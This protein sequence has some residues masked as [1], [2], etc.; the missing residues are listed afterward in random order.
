[1]N[2]LLYLEQGSGNTYNDTRP[3]NILSRGAGYPLENSNISV[4]NPIYATHLGTSLEDPGHTGRVLGLFR[5]E[6]L[7]N[8][9]LD[10][11]LD[12]PAGWQTRSLAH[13]SPLE[14]MPLGL[15]KYFLE[16]RMMVRG[17]P[18]SHL[19]HFV[20]SGHVE[21]VKNE[22]IEIPQR[23][24][25]DPDIFYYRKRIIRDHYLY[26]FYQLPL[27]RVGLRWLFNG[28]PQ[29]SFENFPV[30]ERGMG[31]RFRGHSFSSAFDYL[32]EMTK[33]EGG[34]DISFYLMMPG[35]VIFRRYQSVVPFSGANARFHTRFI[36]SAGLRQVLLEPLHCFVHV[37][38]EFHNLIGQNTFQVYYP[39]GQDRNCFEAS[40]QWA[41]VQHLFQSGS[42]GEDISVVES[43]VRK[44]WFFIMTEAASK[45]KK[46]L[47]VYYRDYLK[48]GYPTKEMTRIAQ[49]VL[50][51][52]GY[53]V[54]VWYKKR[55]SPPQNASW[56]NIINLDTDEYSKD[57]N[58][59]DLAKRIVI[60]QCRDDGC[61]RDD[62]PPSFSASDEEAAYF[63][64]QVNNG[65]LGVML[66]CIGVFP[67]PL[68]LMPDRRP[69]VGRLRQNI[70]NAINE[71][72]TEYMME[73]YRRQKYWE[74]ITPDNLHSLVCAQF[75][76]YRN[77]ETNTLIFAPSAKKQK[78][79]DSN[80]TK[81]NII[82]KRCEQN[83]EKPVYYVFAYDLETV[84]NLTEI[85]E[86]MVYPP[87]QKVLP[88]SY[89]SRADLYEP[90]ESQIPFSCQ[91][92][93]VNVSDRGTYLSRK[94]QE[95]AR[96][97]G[98]ISFTSFTPDFDSENPEFFLSSARTEYSS[99]GN[100]DLGK[101][102]ED[103]LVNMASYV[104]ARGGEQA[105]CFAHNGAHFDAYIVLQFQRFE[106]RNVLKTSRGVMTVS[107]RVP[108][109]M[110]G[111]LMTYDYKVNDLDT[112]KV[113]LILRDTMLQVPGSLARLCKGFN[114]PKEYCKL[115]FPITKVNAQNFHH[116]RLIPL[117]KE[118]GENDVKALAVI[119]V[120]INDL[121]GSSQWKPAKL[122]SLKPPV[123][124][125]VTCMG[126]IR[127]STRIHFHHH[128]PLNQHPKAIDIPALRSWL[129]NA[130]IGGRV[131]AYAKT[132]VSPF[133]GKII[134]AYLDGNRPLLQ[135]LYAD[136]MEAKQCMRVLDFTSLYPFAMDSCPMP[137]GRLVFCTAEQCEHD[138]QR[139]ECHDCDAEMSLCSRHRLFENPSTSQDIRPFTIVIVKNLKMKEDARK[140]SLRNMCP[141]KTFLSST[142]KNVS[143]LYSL[144]HNEEFRK[145]SKEM[146]NVHET[147]SFSNVDLYWMRRQGFTFDIVA[148]FGFRVTNV[149]NLFIGPAFRDRIRAK[150][151]GNK[152]LSDFLKLNYNGSFGITTQQDI[153]DCYFP[154]RVDPSLKDHD[155][156]EPIVRKKIIE[157]LCQNR[158]VSDAGLSVTE[159][160]T[161]EAVYLP[162]GQALFQK[163]KKEHLAEYFADQSPM[164][165]GAAVLSWSR[166]IANL[167]MF[168]VHE[169]DQTYTDTDSICISDYRIHHTPAL[170]KMIIDRDDAPLGSLKN[171][172]AEN[173]GTEPRVFC[174]LIGTKKVKLHIT[175]NKE[176]DVRMF[177]TFK[178]LNVSTELDGKTF[179]AAY[180]EKITS[181]TL[182]HLNVDASTVPPVIVQSWRRNLEFGVSIS[183]HLQSMSPE[184]YFESCAGTSLFTLPHGHLEFF[185]PHGCGVRV[186]YPI[187]INE[188][189]LIM[190]QGERRRTDLESKIYHN[191]FSVDRFKEFI[192][193]Y[194]K[195]IAVE[196]TIEDENVKKA[197]DE[198]EQEIL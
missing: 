172:H 154:V 100:N 186:D 1:M 62:T 16:H 181:Q 35:C 36:R 132:Y 144:E 58:L 67:P 110:T 42:M 34:S 21:R 70:V 179:D 17:I 190:S 51:Q 160:L 78:Q 104:H 40:V 197:F 138:I 83:D 27:V 161:G 39:S 54:E 74:D 140:E 141:R 64:E 41:M 171:D 84:K 163:K 93:A 173:N 85:Q 156:K 9:F 18:A 155:P 137:T 150:Q 65:D 119:I 73:M 79:E 97:G 37:H 59:I 103:M 125:F 153:T 80:N 32:N 149:Y 94:Q 164:Q 7:T 134:S 89:Q 133:A 38:D 126:M 162:N 169:L 192:E 81:K 185:I 56:Q 146:E 183:N 114:V 175:L 82:E 61:V 111:D 75:D 57:G 157:A 30:H 43:E 145:R 143:L 130:T 50:K 112:P 68:A 158:S 122:T 195:D 10:A 117:I 19:N 107:L 116:P 86:S 123:A 196:S 109:E 4:T 90:C 26:S 63:E 33:P 177:N 71:K 15:L 29:S 184:T 47:D 13:G 128:L 187:V 151:E 91:W 120:R 69:Q 72:G 174:S 48:A 127:E 95:H 191:T 152:L 31:I 20:I 131:N 66:H 167:V 108:I 25:N 22:V 129:Q 147:Q 52:T 53:Q 14:G 194:Y 46:S 189:D 180:A 188:E 99:A 55:R 115:D 118:Y 113:T 168:N 11:I 45:S 124:Q 92:I 136:M 139:I 8:E 121:I 102:V 60:F 159:E 5:P 98:P 6:R 182:F 2:R 106:I 176:G 193:A 28:T 87:F 105:F 101:C 23:D 148:G 49:C 135:S 142:G 77:R 166:H 76:R 88:P 198:I 44:R 170:K 24:V 178:G 12:M 165:I 3:Q 96:T